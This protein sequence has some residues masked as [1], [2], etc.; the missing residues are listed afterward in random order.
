[1]PVILTLAYLLAQTV[2]WSENSTWGKHV[3]PI[4][5][6]A[7]VL[8]WQSA[9]QAGESGFGTTAIVALRVNVSGDTAISWSTGEIRTNILPSWTGLAVYEGPPLVA[10]SIYSW[11]AE[12]RVVA[13]SNGT[14]PNSPDFAVA[15]RGTF[16]TVTPQP[17]EAAS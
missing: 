4:T 1:M 3:A 8:R 13:F 7:P 12:E 10:G 15:G 11:T 2:S 16:Q 17:Q 5:T 9:F 6:N 14:R